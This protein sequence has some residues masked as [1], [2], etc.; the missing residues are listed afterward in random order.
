MIMPNSFVNPYYH[1]L[2]P[3]LY[4]LVKGERMLIYIYSRLTDAPFPVKIYSSLNK[5][6]IYIWYFPRSRTCYEKMVNFSV[7]WNWK[8]SLC[9]LDRQKPFNI[10][11]RF[12]IIAFILKLISGCSIILTF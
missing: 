10:I 6:F 2:S 9:D 11:P 1:F 5:R 8:F 7:I 12:C 3:V 4:R